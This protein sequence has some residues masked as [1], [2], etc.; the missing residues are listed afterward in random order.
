M[1][2]DL[3][4]ERAQVR[5][6]ILA[7][8]GERADGEGHTARTVMLAGAQVPQDWVRLSAVRQREIFGA[9]VFGGRHVRR[10]LRGFEVYRRVAFGQDY[11]ISS[12]SH[13]EIAELLNEGKTVVGRKD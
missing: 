4:A 7:D 3:Q 11:N 2:Y 9:A 10:T 1:S 8:Q 6:Q 13:A 12:W 5:A